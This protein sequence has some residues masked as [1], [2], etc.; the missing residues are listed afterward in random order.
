VRW[1][2]RDYLDT[3]GSLDDTRLRFIASDGCLDG[4]LLSSVAEMA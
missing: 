1:D 2:A 4:A 3:W